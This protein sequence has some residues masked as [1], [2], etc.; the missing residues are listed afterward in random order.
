VK[1]TILFL[2]AAVAVNVNA[3]EGM[4]MPQQVPQLASQ[5]RSMGL[6]IDPAQLAD[7]TGD[8][9]GAVIALPGCTASFVSADGLIVTNHHCAFGSIQQNSTA[10]RDLI[11]TGFVARARDQELPAA[12]GTKV[13]VTT[14]IEDVT[15]RITGNVPAKLSDADR[16]GCSGSGRRSSSRSARSRAAF[17]AEFLR[18]FEG[19]QYLRTTQLELSEIKLVYAPARAVG[20]YG[21]EVD[22]FEWPR[23]T[24]DWSLFRAYQNG[25]PYHPQHWLKI[26]TDGVNRG[27][28][29]IVAGYPGRTFRYKTADEV[30]NYKEYVYP[31][32][33]R[34]YGDAI[35]ILE[36]AGK[37]SKDV[38]L[39]NTGRIKGFANTLKNYTSVNE[40]FTKDHILEARLAREEQMRRAIAA[41]RSAAKDFEQS[42]RDRPSQRRA[43]PHPRAR[44][45]LAGFRLIDC[46]AVPRPRFGDAGA[47]GS[48]PSRREGAAEG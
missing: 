29:I 43:L 37:K 24:G 14:R 17:A 42:R 3:G 5:L 47:G 34:Y 44:R 30:R 32:S 23:H 19:S 46:G 7:L 31:S 1:K 39:K 38:A 40:G 13:W 21:G 18:F 48:D 20:E 33:I 15:D 10:E 16:P 36:E 11:T 41:D 28:A 4:W 25:V 35:K 12:P 6:K 26:S 27:D 8:P 22:N 45:I 2:V 9:L